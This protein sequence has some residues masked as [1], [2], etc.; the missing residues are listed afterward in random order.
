M[1]ESLSKLSGIVSYGKNNIAAHFSGQPYARIGIF[2]AR[3]PGAFS[4]NGKK[5]VINYQP[6][7]FTFLL[8]EQ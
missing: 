5:T 1:Y 6:S 3:E 2:S 4:L 7:L 8:K